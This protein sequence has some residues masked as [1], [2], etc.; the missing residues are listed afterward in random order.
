M[1]PTIAQNSGILNIKS[2]KNKVIDWSELETEHYF[3]LRKSHCI[4]PNHFTY[5]QDHIIIYCYG[6]DSMQCSFGSAFSN[7]ISGLA[8]NKVLEQ[9]PNTW[10]LATLLP[11]LDLK[12]GVLVN[13]GK[14]GIF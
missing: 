8:N 7:Y 9:Q 14:R 3:C 4:M 11:Y 2:G 10:S 1:L 12:K 6:T 13:D 5:F